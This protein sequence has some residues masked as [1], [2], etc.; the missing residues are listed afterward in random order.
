M[1]SARADAPRLIGTARLSGQSA[2]AGQDEGGDL[3]EGTHGQHARAGRREHTR[4]RV[5]RG[6]ARD[7]RAHG[8][9]TLS[10][11]LAVASIG[12]GGV[13]AEM[14]TLDEPGVWNEPKLP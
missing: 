2:S 4:E 7:N 1:R 5:R 6:L 9:P 3:G 10:L 8:F 11:L 12:P 13:T 14:A